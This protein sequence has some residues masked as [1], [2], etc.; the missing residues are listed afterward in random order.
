LLSPS[1]FSSQL[2]GLQPKV[3]K[4]ICGSIELAVVGKETLAGKDGYWTEISGPAVRILAPRPGV[5]AQW[6]KVGD[7]TFKAFFYAGP[8]GIVFTRMIVQTQDNGPV[9]LPNDFDYLAPDYLRIA[10]GYRIYGSSDLMYS[11]VPKTDD[12]G[13]ETVTTP[14]GTFSCE[15]FRY[16]HNLGDVWVAR[17]AAPFGLVKAVTKDRTTIT[18]TRLLTNAKDKITAAPRVFDGKKDKLLSSLLQNA[19]LRWVEQDGQLRY[20]FT[21]EQTPLWDIMHCPEE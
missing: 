15:H 7:T 13:R 11:E 9:E 4:F 6:E 2:S 10:A 12:L 8:K 1:P 21:I 20:G 19:G 14:A 3:G 16:Q 17:E 5:L 18:L